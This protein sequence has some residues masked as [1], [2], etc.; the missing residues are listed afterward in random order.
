MIQLEE[1]REIRYFKNEEILQEL[2][3]SFRMG[4]IRVTGIPGEEKEKKTESLF[5]E[6][7]TEKF[8]DLGKGT[9]YTS[10]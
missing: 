8:P 6:I 4:N 3:D 7:V 1:E 2:S 9:R 10:P 5:K